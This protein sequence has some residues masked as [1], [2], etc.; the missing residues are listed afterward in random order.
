MR[1]AIA[2]LLL[3]VAP[4]AQAGVDLTGIDG[5]GG[6]SM[7]YSYWAFYLHLAKHYGWKPQGTTHPKIRNWNGAFESGYVSSDGQ[8]VSKDDAKAIATA[9]RVAIR[10]PELQAVTRRILDGE[11]LRR[12]IASPADLLEMQEL[13][14]LLP[15][16]EK[17]GVRCN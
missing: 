8:V 17:D 1:Q 2:A 7:P 12:L 6:T 10:D 15:L 13:E 9:L 4:V 11:G 5:K 16:L 3:L 14:E